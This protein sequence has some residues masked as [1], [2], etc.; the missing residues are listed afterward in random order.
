[1]VSQGSLQASTLAGCPASLNLRR[2]YDGADVAQTTSY[3]VAGTGGTFY[4]TGAQGTL[5]FIV[6]DSNPVAYNPMP[7]GTTVTVAATPGLAAAVLGGSPIPS[8][9]YP[10]GLA[11]SYKFDDTTTSGSITVTTTTPKGVASSVATLSLVRAAATGTV[12]AC[13]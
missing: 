13:P 12:V 8:T 4:G 5:S 6:A 7:A 3:L 9:A 1:V 10:T 2:F 11:V